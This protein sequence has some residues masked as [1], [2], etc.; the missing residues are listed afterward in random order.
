MSVL[1]QEVVLLPFVKLRPAR[2]F[3]SCSQ[4]ACAE[5]TA[6][7]CN[8]HAWPVF[9][10]LL[11]LVRLPTPVAREDTHHFSVTRKVMADQFVAKGYKFASMQ[12]RQSD[13]WQVCALAASCATA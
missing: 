9:Q 7:T 13:L 11:Q 1:M 12:G 10:A 5:S 8:A 6:Y 3:F 2:S 4:C